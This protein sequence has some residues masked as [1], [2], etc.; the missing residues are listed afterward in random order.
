MNFIEFIDSRK[1]ESIA[2]LKQLV[3]KDSQ[4]LGPTTAQ[5]DVLLFMEA[6]GLEIDSFS[7]N[8]DHLKN[9][10]DYCPNDMAF[11]TETMNHIG[12]TPY[13]PS[14]QSLLMFAHIDTEM[15]DKIECYLDDER[16]YGLGAADDKG[17][18]A[19]ML[20]SLKYYKDF[21]GQLPFNV[22]IMSVIGK[23]GGVGG[24]LIACD[25][26]KY[27]ADAGIYL[28]PAET[29]LGLN[30]LKNIS[31][32]VLDFKLTTTG[33]S[34]KAHVDLDAGHSANHKLVLLTSALVNLNKKR[35]E[36][37]GNTN[38]YGTKLNIGVI[39]G[40]SATGVVSTSASCSFRVHFG[41]EETMES[42]ESEIV[43]CLNQ[44]VLDNQSLFKHSTYKLTKGYL[45]A[46]FAMMDYDHPMI[47]MLKENIKE[48]C[49]I[50]KFIYQAHGASDIRLPM[51]LKNIPTI[52]IGSLCYLPTDENKHEEWIDLKDYLNSIKVLAKVVEKWTK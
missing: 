44:V 19:A 28:H 40:G 10:P 30:E 45:R 36:K 3:E 4:D 1:D 25:R 22:T 47:S 7:T 49:G 43:E 38:E 46:T 2:L 29:G 14:K 50:N 13:D 18:I 20:L 34:P 42:I 52:G 6:L 39:S 16:L 9:L 27:A 12:Y 31:L 23:R 21:Y 8:A 35:V 15:H 32:G 33:E 51:V 37:Y 5:K 48:V 24:T 41:K 17:G 11:H 26:L